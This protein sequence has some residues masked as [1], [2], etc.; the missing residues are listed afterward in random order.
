[1]VYIGS[2]K[3]IAKFI[4]PI[5]ERYRNPDQVWV[6]P[7]VGG[8]NSI[9]EASGIRIGS[10]ANTH[11]IGALKI[12]RDHA[13][14]L[15]KN[16][17]EFTKSDYE[18]IR[19]GADHKFKDFIGYAYSYMGAWFDVWANSDN[20]DYT[21][22]VYRS[23]IIQSPKLKNITLQCN[24]YKD[25]VIPKN[26]LIYCDPPYVNTEGKYKKALDHN[27]FYQWCYTKK[28][29]GH[30]VFLSEYTAPKR[31][32]CIWQKKVK[33]ALGNYGKANHY[34]VKAEKLFI[35]E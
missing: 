27:E 21:R 24:D 18:K 30:T 8:G 22:A 13:R 32:K 29:E 15:P 10:D 7:F 25:L 35:L 14:E 33:S 20:D 19:S 31:F 5:M 3:R 23:A 11:T 4:V 6:E 9:C 26:S 17:S 1:M 34:S 28:E 16:K 12:I 2:K